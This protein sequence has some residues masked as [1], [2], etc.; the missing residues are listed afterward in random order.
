MKQ[1]RVLRLLEYIGTAEQVIEA[2][3]Q[4]GVKGTHRIP[5]RGLVIREA[6]LGETPEILNMPPTDEHSD[7]DDLNR[8][9]TF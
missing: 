8:E 3:E 4:R 1:V 7:D 9:L 2:M 5:G 6:I